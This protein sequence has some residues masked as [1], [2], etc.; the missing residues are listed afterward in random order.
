KV[1]SKSGS[2]VVIDTNTGAIK[3]MANYPSYDPSKYYQTKDLSAFNNA[4]I[5]SPLEVGSIM[6]A[7]TISAGLNQGVITPDTAYHDPGYV[8]LDGSTIKNVLPIPHD[9]TSIKDVLQYSLN[10]GAVHVLKELGGGEFNQR[11]RDTWHDYLV[12]HFQ[13]GRATG[14]EQPN[15]AGGAIPDPDHG[16]ALNLQYANTAFG[17]GMTATTLQ[18][19]AA[20]SSAVNG[21]T[22]YRPHLIEKQVSANGSSKQAGAPVIRKNVVKPSVSNNLQELL[23]YVYTQNHNKYGTNLHDGYN[24][25][26]K[27][28]TGQIPYKGGYKVGV[29][30]GT[31]LGFVGG[32]KPQFAIAVLANEPNLSDFESAGSQAAAPIFGKIADSLINDFGVESVTS[33]NQ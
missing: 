28:G 15:E 18:M 21:G 7:L 29:Y 32:D 19:A 25:G 14:V 27:T 9:P 5:S 30:N 26:G 12:N 11:G 24:I 23:E 2:V 13:L 20:F 10:T 17:Q 3:A 16:S 4:A 6:K 8:T 31:Y 33:S 22:Y 1:H